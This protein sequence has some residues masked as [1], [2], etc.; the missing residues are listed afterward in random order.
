MTHQELKEKVQYDLERIVKD[1]KLESKDKDKFFKWC[2][3]EY[4]I[5]FAESDDIFEIFYHFSQ[6]AKCHYETLISS[7]ILLM[8]DLKTV[9]KARLQTFANN[10]SENELDKSELN[11]WKDKATENKS[12]IEK[13][14]IAGKEMI[15]KIEEFLSF[16]EKYEE[17]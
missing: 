3:E 2:E 16:C 5:S 6:D 17:V 7:Y 12:F 8:D 4:G 14:I 13:E 9:M 15:K 11:I 1:E 10:N